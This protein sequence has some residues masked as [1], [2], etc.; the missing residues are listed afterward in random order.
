[1]GEPIVFSN[2]KSL[3]P[4]LAALAMVTSSGG[5]AFGGQVLVLSSASRVDAGFFAAGTT[6]KLTA[7]GQVNLGLD[8][9]SNPDGSLSGPTGISDYT[10]FNEGG[11]YST[12]YGGD[13][14][15]RYSGGGAN[16]DALSPRGHQFGFAG[17]ESTNT[18]DLGTIRFGTLV[19]T[20]SS[21]PGRSD[22]FSI[23]Y[24]KTLT[25]PVAGNLYLAV[26]DTYSSNN[27]GSYSVDVL[28]LPAAT[29]AAITTPE[30]GTIALAAS[31][32]PFGLV[33]W[34]KRRGRKS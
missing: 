12:E 8:V 22:W 32:L 1:M 27:T 11:S 28:A 5:L 23:G 21:N 17:K 10:Y 4:S 29:P 31:S 15:N 25:A 3:W 34:L 6:L 13:G 14:T 2:L 9:N 7:T 16:L 18:T 20:F 19:G 26:N 24:G 33:V 30:P